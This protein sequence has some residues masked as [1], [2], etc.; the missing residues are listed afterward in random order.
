MIVNPEEKW[1]MKKTV[2]EKETIHHISI[3]RNAIDALFF[4]MKFHSLNSSVRST[5]TIHSTQSQILYLHHPYFVKVVEDFHWFDMCK[6]CFPTRYDIR[7]LFIFHLNSTFYYVAIFHP[8]AEDRQFS[9]SWLHWHHHNLDKIKSCNDKYSHLMRCREKE[10]H[11][12][13]EIG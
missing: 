2:R 9:I 12:P 13:D 6:A 3:W 5:L 4:K 8:L 10:N 7:W 1:A 11:Q